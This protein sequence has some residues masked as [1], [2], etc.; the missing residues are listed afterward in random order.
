MISPQ[1]DALFDAPPRRFGP[2]PLWWWSGAAVTEDRLAWQLERFDEGGIHNL[3]VINLAPAGPLFGALA[4]DPPWFS[5]TW[6]DRFRLTCEIAAERDLRVWFYDQ[7]GFSGANLQGQIT[8]V[9]PD[10]AGRSLRFREAAVADGRVPLHGGEALVGAFDPRGRRLDSAADGAVTGR[11]GEVVRVVVSAPT[12][13]DYLAPDAVARII[14]LVHGEYDRRVPEH[15][16]RAI[17]GSFQDEAPAANAWTDRFAEEFR[18]R[19]GYDLLDHLPSLF[20]GASTE[21]RKIRGDYHAVRAALAEEAFFRPLARWHEERGMLIGADQANPARAG[22]PTQATQLYTDYIR[23]HRWYGAVGSDHEGDAKIHSSIAHLYDHP[24]VWMESFHSSG[25]GGTLADTY[26]WLLPLLRSGANLY[27]P[28]ATYFGTA[29]GWFEWAPPS[30]DW[31]QPYWEQYPAFSRAVARIASIMSWGVYDAEV[32]VLH[33]TATA[34]AGLTLDLPVDH[35][36]DGILG[37]AAYSDLDAA[38]EHYLALVGSTNW[39]HPRIGA[40]DRERV[41]FDVIDDDSLTREPLDGAAV[42]VS[43]QRYRAVVLPG[44]TVLEEPTARRLLELLDAGGRVIVVGADPQ[45]AAGRGGDDA[46]VAALVRHARLERQADAAAAARSLNELRGH[47]EAD[48]PLLVRRSGRDGAALVTGAFPGASEPKGGTDPGAARGRAPLDPG[49]YARD[50]RVTVRARVDEA[51]VL[52]PATGVR[53]RPRV[54]SDGDVSTISFG[55]GGAP[56]VILVWRE[57]DGGGG[58]DHG[59]D[60]S[61]AVDLAPVVPER[62]RE[63]RVP[64]DVPWTGELRP[65]LDNTWGDFALPVGTDV[66]ALQIWSFDWQERGA[67]GDEFDDGG[68]LRVRATF[69]ER[70]RT[71]GPVP[72]EHAPGPLSAT[73]VAA[74]LAGDRALAGADWTRR[75]HSTSRGAADLGRGTLGN[76]GIVPE[77]FVRLPAGGAGEVALVRTIVETGLRGEVE[78][79]VGAGADKQVWWNG[80]LVAAT[81]ANTARAVVSVTDPTNVLEYR[82]GASRNRR[83]VA[84]ADEVLESWFTLAPAGD[85]GERP[86]FMR[87]PERLRPDGS[88]RFTAEIE[89]PEDARAARLI[90]GAAVGATISVDGAVVARQ[91]KVEYYEETWGATPAYFAHDVTGLLGAGRHRV[92][93]EL[94]STRVDDVVLV[95]LVATTSDGAVALVSGPGWQVEADGRS[96]ESVEHLGHWD[97]PASTHAVLRAHPLPDVGWLRGEPVLGTGVPGFRTTD[98]VVPAAQVLRFTVPA[99]S[100]EIEI[101]LRLPARVWVDGAEVPVSAGRIAIERPLDAPG[102]VLVRTAETVFARGGSALAGPVRVR[103]APAPIELGDWRDIGLGSWS[104]GVRYTARIEV[105]GDAPAAALELGRVQGSVRVEVDGE[106][107]ADLFC[108]PYR[109]ELGDR[110]GELE[111]SVTVYTTLAPFLAESTP[112]AW[113]FPEQLG[114]GLIGPVTLV[115]S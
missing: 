84:N 3:V 45:F 101:P 20:E 40:L 31:R 77:G 88:A 18:S 48:V 95:D 106:V 94:E 17:A 53:S 58:A 92:E 111:V 61:P 105:A 112:T 8:S 9:H 97:E 34:Q 114:S 89:L 68:W 28:H 79:V 74:V 24:R 42:R 83:A 6:W 103:T 5:E 39:F 22:Y 67:G 33:P 14:D 59:S 50:R 87:L 73:E 109:V 37:G 90:V 41:A 49:R 93:V 86:V 4:D 51:M 100:T 21:A 26:D 10:A 25:W 57:A 35:F 70:V 44:A 32:A 11:D 110:R 13:F 65:T 43:A 96:G 69:G 38:Q 1:L 19:R 80:E 85:F 52:D 78:L 46:V 99:G 107:V 82:L 66:A 98:D 55:T 36:G 81:S 75:V 56:A 47:A 91:A 115:T 72:V 54:E 30:T 102:T 15:L 113:A 71:L 7:I 64:V 23:T 62:G 76:K 104:G 108:A 12:A 27:N 63:R 29:G 2:T 60:R 16:G